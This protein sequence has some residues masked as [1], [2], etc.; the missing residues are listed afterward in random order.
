M[1]SNAP[2]APNCRAPTGWARGGRN[3]RGS[4]RTPHLRVV[5]LPATHTE[6]QA[7]SLPPA[8]GGR[9][10]RPPAQAGHPSGE[11]G[12]VTQLAFAEPGP[13]QSPGT[14]LHCSDPRP[15]CGSAAI[16]AIPGRAGRHGGIEEKPDL[17]PPTGSLPWLQNASD[18]RG[19]G[20]SRRVRREDAGLSDPQCE[21]RTGQYPGPRGLTAT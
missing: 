6:C 4:V 2:G 10:H 8:A 17:H 16:T 19:P 1:Q 5:T 20:L 18:R 14:F 9:H 13:P 15:L 12:G 11:L 7:P 21:G 3:R